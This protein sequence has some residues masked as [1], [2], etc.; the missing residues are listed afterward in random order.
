MLAFARRQAGDEGHEFGLAV[1]AAFLEHGLELR[2]HGVHREPRLTE[3]QKEPPREF[4]EI[5]RGNSAKHNPKAQSWM[6]RIR[7]FFEG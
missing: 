1:G 2:A 5:S 7:G 6:D 4:D 3:Q